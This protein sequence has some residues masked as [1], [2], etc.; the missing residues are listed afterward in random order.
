MRVKHLTW[1]TENAWRDDDPTLSFRPDL[2]L[3]FGAT[4]VLMQ[5]CASRVLGEQFPT[6]IRLGCST[7]TLVTGQ[8]LDDC[9][10]SAMAL[11]LDRTRVRLA[12]HALVPGASK[13]AGAAIGAQL[14]ADDLAGIFLLCDGLSV[15]GSD[16]VA[17][18]VAAVGSEVVISGGL[19]AD[20]PRFANTLVATD[21]R[22]AANMVAAVGF[23]GK[24]IHI[25]HGSAGGWDGFGPTRR[26]TRADGNVL[27]ELDGRPALELYERY[28]GEEAAGLP[29][30]ALLYPLNIWDTAQ[31]GDSTVRTVLSID[32]NDGSMVFAG[33]MPQGWSARLMRGSFDR[34]N[35]GASDA[36]R[37]ALRSFSDKGITP[38]ACL[39]VSCVGRRLLMG[40]RAEDEVRAVADVLGDAIPVSGFYSYGE[41]APQNVSGFCGLHNQTVTLTL[42][43]ETV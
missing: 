15:N 30:S 20:G 24:A 3:Y 23:Y 29:A 10:A 21:G 36:A 41:I 42:L 28:L 7:G 16:L 9:G 25:A 40:Q 31:P 33:D 32:R 1:T 37:H 8:N 17:G 34:L 27:R 13:A 4:D 18:L 11:G 12:T 5:G 19:A 14:A 35:E 39:F 26:I 22:P 6:A 38:Q 43:A 2:I